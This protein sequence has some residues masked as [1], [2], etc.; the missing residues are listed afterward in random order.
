MVDL[1][2]SNIRLVIGGTKD[3]RGGFSSLASIGTLHTDIVPNKD[4]Y[5]GSLIVETPAFVIKHARDYMLFMLID[6]NVKFYNSD[7]PGLL[8]ISL[9]MANRCQ[10]ADNL[11]P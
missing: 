7:A 8:N 3:R 1:E 11:C 9:A 5:R 10:F 6:R 2:L 4:L